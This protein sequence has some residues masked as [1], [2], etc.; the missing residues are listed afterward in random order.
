MIF[1]PLFIPLQFLLV[2]EHA[3]IAC[4]ISVSVS[5]RFMQEL[6]KLSGQPMHPKPVLNLMLYYYGKKSIYM[7]S[8]YPKKKDR[9][10]LAIQ[11]EG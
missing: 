11:S 2:D 8:F 10:V 6:N 1:V 9:M 4:D 5:S 7:C 3:R